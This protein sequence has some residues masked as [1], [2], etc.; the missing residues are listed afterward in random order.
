LIPSIEK[1]YRIN[2][3][4]TSLI[5][6]TY[7]MGFI[8]AAP[9][10]DTLDWK[11]GRSRLYMI[12]SISLFVGYT[13]IICQPPF[14]L[15]V[16]SFLFLG[17]GA[18]TLLASSNSWLVNLVNGAVI[19]SLMQ[20]FYGVCLP[21]ITLPK[22][23]AEYGQIG[24]IVAPLIAT[25]LVSRGIRW[26]FFYFV[27]L[28]ISLVQVFFLGWSYKDFEKDAPVQLHNVL[29]R[30]TSRQVGGQGQPTK[31]QLLKMSLKSRTTALGALFIL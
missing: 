22:T 31:M 3:A 7:A 24:G 1:H 18:A 16:I 2:Y 26:S 4:T 20:A 14:P 8:L 19:V 15:T 30:T 10:L 6:I 27:P 17:W 25:A 13:M 9:M 21:S 5:F 29:S 28:A 11:L 23:H 12:A